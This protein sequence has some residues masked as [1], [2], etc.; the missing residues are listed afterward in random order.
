MNLNHHL[1]ERSQE[2]AMLPPI[3]SN[4]SQRIVT[5]KKQQKEKKVFL[6]LFTFVK[7]LKN[8]L[9]LSIETYCFIIF[10]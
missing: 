5:E 1:G 8:R 6:S 3:S 9:F 4:A 7:Q 2:E 10:F